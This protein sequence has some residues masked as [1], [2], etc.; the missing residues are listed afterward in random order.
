MKIYGTVVSLTLLINRTGIAADKAGNGSEVRHGIAGQCFENNIGVT[1]P[2][3]F[4]AGSDAF[5]I[6]EQNNF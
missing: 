5:G 6:G 2:F 4:S 1:V 3:D